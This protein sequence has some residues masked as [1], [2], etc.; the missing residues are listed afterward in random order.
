MNNSLY[1]NN[2]IQLLKS[3]IINYTYTNTMNKLSINSK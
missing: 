1:Y 3:L 2:E